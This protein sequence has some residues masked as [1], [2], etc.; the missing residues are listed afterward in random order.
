MV[1]FL[2]SLG[3][4]ISEAENGV[5]CLDFISHRMPDLILMD[6]QMPMM[7]GY[8]A[9]AKL[10]ERKITVPIIVL[11]GFIES[12][13]SKIIEGY[14]CVRKPYKLSLISDLIKQKYDRTNVC[15]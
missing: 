2:T 9:I 14:D 5:E 4:E 11:S 15:R 6:L 13:N 12:D 7:D 3:H 8:T 10:K 1:E